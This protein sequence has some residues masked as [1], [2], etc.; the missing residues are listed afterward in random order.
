MLL[1]SGSRMSDRQDHDDGSGDP[2]SL[3][4]TYKDEVEHFSSPGSSR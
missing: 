3:T 2:D 1:C 4:Q